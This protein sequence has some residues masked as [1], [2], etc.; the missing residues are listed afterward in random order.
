MDLRGIDIAAVS[1]RSRG[2]L[3]KNLE[4]A[5]Y[6]VG[7]LPRSKGTRGG[8]VNV[9]GVCIASLDNLMHQRLL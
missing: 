8:Q 5:L 7:F 4:R 1:E 9:A 6:G 2:T 3:Q